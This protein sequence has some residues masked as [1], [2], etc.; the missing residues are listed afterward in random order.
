MIDHTPEPILTPPEYTVPP[1]RCSVCLSAVPEAL[2]FAGGRTI[3]R[4]CL[5]GLAESSR[6]TIDDLAAMLCAA[7]VE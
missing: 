7:V 6:I 3:C 1:L 4:R 2:E 5:G